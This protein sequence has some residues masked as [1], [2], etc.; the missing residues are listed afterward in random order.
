MKDEHY[1]YSI[2][3]EKRSERNALKVG[4]RTPSAHELLVLVLQNRTNSSHT[5]L[6]AYDVGT[7]SSTTE[8]AWANWEKGFLIWK[9]SG[10]ER[11]AASV[12]FASTVW[13]EL[14]LKARELG[15]DKPER[16]APLLMDEFKRDMESRGL[17]PQSIR[18]RLMVLND[19]ANAI[20]WNELKSVA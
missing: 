10:Q 15:L 19:I 8:A 11:S 4:I 18:K 3:R 1:I 7:E 17:S 9:T 2:A 6:A 5:S 14:F 12:L 13:R 20:F 16:L